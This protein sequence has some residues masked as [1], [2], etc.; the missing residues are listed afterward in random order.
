MT[1]KGQKRLSSIYDYINANGFVTVSELA[2]IF[3]VSDSTIKRDLDLLDEQQLIQ[4]KHG[5]AFTSMEGVTPPY[6][7]RA[8]AAA[9]EKFRIARAA[10][11]WIADGDVLFIDAGS[12]NFAMYQQIAADN[13]TVFTNSLAI[14]TAPNRHVAHVYALE[15]EVFPKSMI[16]RGSLAVENLDRIN[17][18]KIFFSS[19]G[20]SHDYYLLN[21]YAA[22]CVFIRRLLRMDCQKFLLLDSSKIVK[23]GTFRSAPIEKVDVLITDDQMPA[24]A[25]EAIRAKG[26]KLIIV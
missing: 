7:Y 17:P 3:S 6:A 8:K 18:D 14:L 15:G 5:G 16:L 19:M 9:G 20:L 10:C 24:S 4:R 21:R 22:D 23:S 11:E 26:I 1:T 25:V 12:T 13:I 2:E